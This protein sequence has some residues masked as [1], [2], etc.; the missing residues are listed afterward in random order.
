VNS[1][2]NSSSDQNKNSLIQLEQELKEVRIRRKIAREK[3]KIIG[4]Y[5]GF[6]TN[7]AT[8]LGLAATGGLETLDP[9][10]LEII[11]QDPLLVFGSGLGLLGGRAAINELGK[12][13][14]A[15]RR[16]DEDE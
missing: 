4:D 15:L 13:Y 10:F 8:G 1:N 12:I 6:Y 9:N 5:I 3:L 2:D 11:L 7:K 16:G 14:D